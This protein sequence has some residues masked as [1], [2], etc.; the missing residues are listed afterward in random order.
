MA[1]SSVKGKS[2]ME[3]FLETFEEVIDSGA[4]KMDDAQL[5]KSEKKINEIV[6]RAV[7]VRKRRRETA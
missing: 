3:S 1:T 6:D 2:A 5:R 7:A 4:R